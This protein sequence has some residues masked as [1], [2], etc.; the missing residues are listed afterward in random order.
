MEILKDVTSD[1]QCA[2]LYASELQECISEV[3]CYSQ[4]GCWK[5]N[6]YSKMISKKDIWFTTPNSFFLTGNRF[7]F[8]MAFVGKDPKIVKHALYYPDALFGVSC[9]P[10]QSEF[11]STIQYHVQNIKEGLPTMY[12]QRI[13]AIRD[14]GAGD[15]GAGD[16]GATGKTFFWYVLHVDMEYLNKK[17][18]TKEISVFYSIIGDLEVLPE[19]AAW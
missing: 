12:C 8:T 13:K 1:L 7:Y 11:L 9:R 4:Q 5:M 16:A 6:D 2:R 19:S 10:V 15:A 18:R 14:A 17:A 3:L